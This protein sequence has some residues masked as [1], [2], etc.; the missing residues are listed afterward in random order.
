MDLKKLTTII[1]MV[2]GGVMIVWGLLANDWSKCW[3]AVVI[4]G[5]LLCRSVLPAKNVCHPRPNAV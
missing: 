1:P 3:I 5:I 4:G 2:S